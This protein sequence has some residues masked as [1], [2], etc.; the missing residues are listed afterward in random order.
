[1]TTTNR[2]RQ[3]KEEMNM[4]NLLKRI[5]GLPWT[6]SI[7]ADR[8]QGH[9][10]GRGKLVANTQSCAAMS[11]EQAK[12]NL[13]Y[14]TRPVLLPLKPL[15]AVLDDPVS[16]CPIKSNVATGLFGFN[17]F[18]LQNL[19]AFRLESPIEGRV[20]QQLPSHRRR[21]YFVTHNHK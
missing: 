14:L 9:I 3:Q 4:S 11:P 21:S 17:P 13:A 6:F 5:I 18:V 10:M 2:E 7:H 1:M 8:Q 12:A 16:Q 19:L 20:F 15:D